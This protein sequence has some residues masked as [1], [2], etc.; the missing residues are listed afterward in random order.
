MKFINVLL[1]NGY[2]AYENSKPSI[3]P[4]TYSTYNTSQYFVK[5]EFKKEGGIR[6]GLREINKPPTLIHPR[7]KISVF[8]VDGKC[9]AYEM[10]DDAMNICLD[11]ENNQL[12]LDVITGVK[13]V[14]K[15]FR[16]KFEI[17]KHQQV[18]N[19]T[20]WD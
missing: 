20:E 2:I 3:F 9:I 11:N 6:F 13:K 14:Q 19:I 4:Y 10:Q 16:F 8:D 7:P 15:D 17:D 1:S 18:K 12:I 5:G